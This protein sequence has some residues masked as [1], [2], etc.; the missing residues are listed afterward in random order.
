[1][2]EDASYICQSC[3]EEIVVPIDLTAGAHQEYVED[4]PVCCCPNLIRVDIESDG[5]AIVTA[6]LE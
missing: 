5:T 6:K 4:C 3:G 1:M 2:Q